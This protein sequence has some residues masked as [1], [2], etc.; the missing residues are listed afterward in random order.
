VRDER[1]L[2]TEP[3]T[4]NVYHYGVHKNVENLPP[5]R[6][7]MS[8]IIDHY[9]NVQQDVLETF[10]D[11]GPLR[12]LAAPTML[13]SGRRIPGLKLDHP[14][15]L[16][17]MPSLVRFANVAAGGRFTTADLYHPALDALGLTESRY[18]L[19]SFR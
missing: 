6:T 14:R 10:I 16:A 19:A 11:R 9:H 1:L 4:H 18:S 17:V 12:K 7:R 15:P 2:R 5:L 13:P 8:E 3:A